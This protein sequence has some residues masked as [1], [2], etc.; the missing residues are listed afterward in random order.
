MPPEE[1]SIKLSTIETIDYAIYD[2]LNKELDLFATTNSGW[3]KIPTIWVSSERAFQIK[4]D[5][6]L[7]DASGTLILPLVTIERASVT[8]DL[9]KKGAF[10]ANITAVNDIKGGS[11]TISKRINQ[12]KTS[13]Y[14]N[15]D[16]F[17]KKGQR[18]FPRKNNKIV[19]QHISIPM[20]VYI[21]VTYNITLRT[22]YQQQMNEIITP[23]IN[24]GRGINYFG[25]ERDGHRYEG[26]VDSD[27]AHDNNV[28][29]MTE[30]ERSFKTNIKINVLGYLIG[31]DKNDKQ[32]RVVIRENAVEVKIPR[33]RVIFGDIQTHID[34]K[35]FYRE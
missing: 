11:I 32:P 33:E 1:Y 14:A 10:Y 21:D 22:E 15:A 19:Y 12:D 4:N 31:N 3:E 23:F 29:E 24:V 2:W 7:R 16:T 35:G 18:F 5:K 17:R 34:E 28:S 6:D 13:N 8:K 26:F 20:P 25:L 9:G 27:F 30:E